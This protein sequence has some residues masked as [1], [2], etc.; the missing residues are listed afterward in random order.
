MI[1]INDNHLYFQD[2]EINQSEIYLEGL[3]QGSLNIVRKY[4]Y[5]GFLHRYFL[6]KGIVSDNS[7]VEN[8]ELVNH[9]PFQDSGKINQRSDAMFIFSEY[10]SQLTKFD[11]LL[12][13]FHAK[14]HK[15]K[16]FCLQIQD[17]K[18]G[19]VVITLSINFHR[20]FV[21]LN[22]YILIES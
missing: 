18:E 21:L 14:R 12:Q 15:P 22:D 16:L 13:K 2:I 17:G 4:K 8:L 1:K 10:E 9:R 6:T 3:R 11:E 20:N 19:P 5:E 7:K